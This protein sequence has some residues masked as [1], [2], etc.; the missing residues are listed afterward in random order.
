MGRL[1][2][3]QTLDGRHQKNDT[4]Q[5]NDTYQHNDTTQY[6]HERGTPVIKRL[7]LLDYG[8][9]RLVV[10]YAEDEQ[11][12]WKE[13]TQWA[14]ERNIPLPPGATLKRFPNG[15]QLNTMTLP[16]TIQENE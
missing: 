13:A 9:G 16:G 2:Q 6:T 1:Y 15:F 5:Y 14:I 4:Y 3:G 7:Y 10:I 12:A 8:N 11:A